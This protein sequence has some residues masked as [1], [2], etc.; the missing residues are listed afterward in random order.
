MAIAQ[1][2]RGLPNP[3]NVRIPE[4]L[5]QTIREQAMRNERTLSGQVRWLLLQAVREET[6]DQGAE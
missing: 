2:V 6:I 5:V 1:Q 4:Q 3:I